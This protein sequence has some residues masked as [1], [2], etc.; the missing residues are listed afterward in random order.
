MKKTQPVTRNLYEGNQLIASYEVLNVEHIRNLWD[1][2]NWQNLE[3]CSGVPA[4]YID[5]IER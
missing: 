1:I 2:V 3:T 4:N 5:T